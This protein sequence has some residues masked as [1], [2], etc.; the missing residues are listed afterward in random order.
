M[1][2]THS[3]TVPSLT[4]CSNCIRVDFGSV[5]VSVPTLRERLFAVH[6]AVRPLSRVHPHVHFQL[7]FPYEALVAARAHV[8]SVPRVVA[9]VHLQLRQAAVSPSALVTLVAGPHLHVVPAVE[10]KAAGRPEGLVALW[11]LVGFLSGVHSAVQLEAGGR[12]EA[13]AADGT[14]VRPLS[15]VERLVFL[16]LV[17]VQEGLAADGAAQ[18]LL[19][20][21]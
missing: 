11:A 14:E 4:L 18:R 12:W 7:V 16:Q 19:A 20:L 9:L 17:L 8:R 15:G 13:T 21:V 10:P 5:P 6:T 2:P 3:K 1:L